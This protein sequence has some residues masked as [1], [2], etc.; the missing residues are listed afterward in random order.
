[1]ALCAAAFLTGCSG[2]GSTDAKA[3]QSSAAAAGEKAYYRCLERNGLVLEKR[4]DGQLRVD[5]DVN[6]EA[7]MLEAQLKCQDQLPTGV[8]EVTA[9]VPSQFLA[10]AEEV[11]ACLRENGFLEYPDP[12]TG[13]AKLT[14]EQRKQYRTPEFQVALAKCAPGE[15]A[16]GD[17]VGG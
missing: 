11:T 6:E 2:G 3:A 8:P 16:A 7:T 15:G 9:P 12:A 5:K 17:M 4:D 14:D 1:M 13:E 10:R